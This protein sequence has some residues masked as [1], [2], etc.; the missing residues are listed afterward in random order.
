[1][2]LPFVTVRDGQSIYVRVCGRGEPVVLLPGLGMK[3][4]QWLPFILPFMHRF[5]FY[6][7][8][9]RGSGRS[10]A[11]RFNQPDIF[12]NHMEDVQDIIQHFGLRDFSL[13]G[14]SLGAST[15]L[16]LQ[17]A[18]G[19]DG[20]R[21][22]LHVEQSPCIGN[23]EGWPYGV[24]GDQQGEC[25]AA[26]QALDEVLEAHR[27]LGSLQELP[28]AARQEVVH[29]LGDTYS[30]ILGKRAL[31]P[32]LQASARWPWLLSKLFPMSLLADI[33]AY[34]SSYLSGGHDYRESLRDCPAPVTVMVGMRS[35]LYD[36]RGQVAI[37]DYAPEC[38][39]VRLRNA[40]HVP[41]LEAPLQFTRELG[42]FLTR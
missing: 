26:L 29:I 4:R 2:I 12:Q 32:L 15:A 18:G 13:A 28:L 5:R 3:S 24:F 41:L 6:M 31:A 10:S 35:P 11:V 19:F 27:D 1:M 16:H 20:V 17:R 9:F 23:R 21:R 8:D 34:L 33:R 22:Y 39:L 40:G 36:S 25:F 38:R 7:P 37:A 30:R 14:Y 42:R